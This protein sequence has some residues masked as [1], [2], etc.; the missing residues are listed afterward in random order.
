MLK[1]PTLGEVEIAS[2][3]QLIKW[4]KLL[5]YPMGDHQ[6]EVMD[7]I[8]SVANDLGGIVPGSHK[9]DVWVPF[10]SISRSE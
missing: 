8:L 10:I 5:P 3:A 6:N 7:K 4:Y 9:R 2:M 1:Y